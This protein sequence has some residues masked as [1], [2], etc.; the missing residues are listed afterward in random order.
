MK[1]FKG[2]KRETKG[3]SIVV[4]KEDQHLKEETVFYRDK[5]LV[6]SSNDQKNQKE[7]VFV[8]FP[9]KDRQVK[10]R[11]RAERK[12]WRL[13]GDVNHSLKE[14][15]YER[16]IVKVSYSSQEKETY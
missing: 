2:D 11:L 10:N 15:N 12:I 7:E 9:A 5:K 6:L 16:P 4:T 3:V 1:R 14:V 8:Y 13:T